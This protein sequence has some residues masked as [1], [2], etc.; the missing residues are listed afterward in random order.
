MLR[1]R[2]EVE[3][4]CRNLPRRELHERVDARLGIQVGE[5]VEQDVS[6]DSDFALFRLVV[7]AREGKEAG[8][9]DFG[10]DFV[11]GT[12]EERFV[13]LSWGTRRGEAW[14]MFA[15]TKVPLTRIT[16]ELVNRALVEGVPL[17]AT[18]CLTDPKGRRPSSLRSEESVVWE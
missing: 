14:A 9:L 6:V 15:R 16:P 17:R 10:G 13:Y 18:L 1:K 5:R 3:F 4:M 12:A 2:V 7:F 11:K 8:S